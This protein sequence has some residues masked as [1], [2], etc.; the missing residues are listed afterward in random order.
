MGK[1]KRGNCNNI[2]GR[3]VPAERIGRNRRRQRLATKRATKAKALQEC[4]EVNR[5]VQ[6]STKRDKRNFIDSL[7]K[8][9]EEANSKR[10]HETCPPKKLSTK[11]SQPEWL[12]KSSR[13]HGQSILKN[14]WTDELTPPNPN[15]HSTCKDG[16]SHQLWEAHQ[17]GNEKSQKTPSTH[18]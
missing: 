6:K 11:I 1:D 16:L 10:K 13:R 17:A 14:S 2:S 5:K 4:I 8:E 12:V 7:A 15:R 18:S 9:S 3:D